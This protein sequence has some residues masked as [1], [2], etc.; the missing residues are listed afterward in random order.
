MH[1]IAAVYRRSL[2]T[3]KNGLALEAV[4]PKEQEAAKGTTRMANAMPSM[5]T[6]APS[7]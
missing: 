1:T 5:A 2:G 7:P 3:A 4:P 6:K